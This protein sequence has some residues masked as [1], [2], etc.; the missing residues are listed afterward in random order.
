MMN[1]FN[2]LMEVSTMVKKATQEVK[3]LTKRIILNKR[4]KR[5]NKKVYKVKTKKIVHHG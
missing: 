1:T 5:L 2:K 4:Q 3:S